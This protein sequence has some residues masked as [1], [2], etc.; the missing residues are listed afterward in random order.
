M[1]LFPRGPLKEGLKTAFRE[2]VNFRIFI[3]WENKMKS[4]SMK[5]KRTGRGNTKSNIFNPNCT[6]YCNN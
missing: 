6:F 5:S 4:V 2:Q 3:P 1:R